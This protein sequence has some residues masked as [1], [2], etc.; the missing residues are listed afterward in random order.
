[1]F[2]KHH[3][4]RRLARGLVA[5]VLV[6]AALA[7]IASAQVL[8]SGT[9]QISMQ[10]VGQNQAT[11]T[12]STNWVDIPAAST[13]VSLPH[14]GSLLVNARFTAESSCTGAVAGNCYVRILARQ[15]AIELQLNPI[16]DLASFDGDEA[17]AGNDG[18][19]SH[20]IERS[21]RLVGSGG[22]TIVVQRRVSAAT[23]FFVVD[24]WHLAV[25]TST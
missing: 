22:W 18:I 8:S 12:S 11:G 1:M 13:D 21:R 17:G 10:N 2:G 25:E 14:S 7:G 15:G 9:S 19:E 6:S 20:A 4:R 23:T 5:G 16:D 3:P 24:D